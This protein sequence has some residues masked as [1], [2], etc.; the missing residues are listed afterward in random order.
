MEHWADRATRKISIYFTKLCLELGLSANQATLISGVVGIVAGALLTSPDPLYWLV[1]IMTFFLFF[2]FDA[3]DG[4]IAR[5]NKSSSAV[6]A[7]FE[8]TVGWLVWSYIIACISWGIYNSLH[9][10]KVFIFGFVAVIG[11]LVYV[12]SAYSPYRILHEERTLIQTLLKTRNM[13][14]IFVNEPIVIKYGETFFGLRGFIPAILTASII[15][16]LMSPFIIG[17]FLVN[18]RFMYLIAFGLAALAGVTIRVYNVFRSGVKL[19]K[20]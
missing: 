17:S 10:I 13:R 4:E 12:T 6:G 20:C 5:Y 11:W 14:Y 15:D 9:D 1:G 2:I 3:V 19:Q 16:C 8:L 7:Y 18:A